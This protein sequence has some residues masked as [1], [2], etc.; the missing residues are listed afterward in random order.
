MWGSD[1]PVLRHAGDSYAGWVDA[2]C[3]LVG[4]AAPAALAQLFEGSAKR[5]Y[6]IDV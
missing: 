2:T 4:T 1:W 6:A 5:F 3:D